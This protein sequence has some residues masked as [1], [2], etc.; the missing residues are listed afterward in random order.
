VS[1]P[2][3]SFDA[4]LETALAMGAMTVR[5]WAGIRDAEDVDDTQR[6]LIVEDIVRIAEKAAQAGV[7][8]G[9]EYH[10]GTLTNSPHST[11]RLMREVP[12]EAVRFYWQAP[13]GRSPEYCLDSLRC[14]LPR[15]AH[16]HVFHWTIGAGVISDLRSPEL[17]SLVWPQDYHRHPLCDGAACWQTYLECASSAPSDHWALLEFTKDDD[18][19]Q[20]AEDARVLVSLLPTE[21][22]D[23]DGVKA[24]ELR[25]QPFEFE[26]AAECGQEQGFAA[27]GQAKAKQVVA[28]ADEL[29]GKQRGQ[30]PADLV[31][32]A[33]RVDDR[34][35]RA[36]RQ[37]RNLG[38]RRRGGRAA[39]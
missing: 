25:Y 19:R 38:D 7:T 34:P 36:G 12:Q 17:K 4:V 26:V 27:A 30:L 6:A 39:C 37:P 11:A 35:G 28:A 22:V 20:L 32:Q 31:R 3:L 2:N 15:L 13:F 21:I 10:H 29:A 24:V 9:F 8:L 18:W 33:R 5:V 1:Q 16:V 23:G 14:L